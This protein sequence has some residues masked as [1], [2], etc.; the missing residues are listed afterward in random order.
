MVRHGETELTAQQRYSGRGDVPL[1]QRGE[2]QAMAAAVRV[3][4]LAPAATAVVTSPLVRCR[5]TAELIAEECGGLPVTV[6]PQVIECD[7]GAWEGLTFADVQQRWPAEMTAWLGST[8]VAPPG[9][10]SFQAVAKRVRAA[11]AALCRS[12]PEQ[13]VVLVSHVSPLKLL[14]RDALA[15]GDGF[16]HRLYLDAAGV[17]VVDFYPDGGVAVR[18]VNETAHLR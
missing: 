16:L 5:R 11:L 3:A 9:G 14:L 12:Y 6:E 2:A 18:V 17:S 7:F 4:S 8:A 1:S 10:E 15:A 13:T